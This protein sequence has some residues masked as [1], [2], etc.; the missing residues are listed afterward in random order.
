MPKP[1]YV[2]TL[3]PPNPLYWR[4]QSLRE[5]GERVSVAQ[6]L[7]VIPSVWHWWW[8]RQ[9]LRAFDFYHRDR[10]IIMNQVRE[11][12]EGVNGGLN[13]FDPTRGDILDWGAPCLEEI[14][15]YY[16][17]GGMVK[18]PS[19]SLEDMGFDPGRMKKPS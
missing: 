18:D 5:L 10:R 4:L 14:V 15:I 12:C 8:R 16:F 6:S 11:F 7:L 19:L 17:K 13:G 1:I 9:Y 3:T 2:A